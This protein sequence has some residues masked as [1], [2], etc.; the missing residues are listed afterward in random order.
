MANE[1]RGEDYTSGDIGSVRKGWHFGMATNISKQASVPPSRAA[2][3]TMIVA[4]QQEYGVVMCWPN[5]IL[6]GKGREL[7]STSGP[8]VFLTVFLPVFLTVFLVALL[9]NCRVIIIGRVK[10]VGSKP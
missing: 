3:K 9:T 4:Y 1:G 7:S 2:K 5:H 10:E 6:I 8:L